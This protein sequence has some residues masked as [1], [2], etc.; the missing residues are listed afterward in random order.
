[1]HLPIL[2]NWTSLFPTFGLLGGIYHFVQILKEASL[3]KQW[4]PDQTPRFVASDLV[5]HYLPMPHK[6]DDR[7]KWVKLLARDKFTYITTEGTFT[8]VIL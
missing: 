1:M 6:K 2:I 7:L 4:K 8:R 3:S 5:L